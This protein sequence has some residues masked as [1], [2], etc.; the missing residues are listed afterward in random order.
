GECSADDSFTITIGTLFAVAPTPMQACDNDGDGI[1]IVDLTTKIPEITLGNSGV[2]VTFHQTNS[3]AQAGANPIAN[4]SNY[5]LEIAAPP[6]LFVRVTNVSGLCQ[7]VYPLVFDD[8]GCTGNFVS[9]TV[10]Y[11]LD[12]NGC[13][14]NDVPA[15][16]VAVS[17]TQGNTYVTTFTDANGN[18][19]LQNMEDGDV[20]VFV[21]TSGTVFTAPSPQTIT[22]PGNG[23][24]TNFCITAPNPVTDISVSVTPITQARPGFAVSYSLVF[25]NLGTTQ[26]SGNISLTFPTQ[27]MTFT[28][29]APAMVQSGNALT[30]NY[31]NLMPFETR[32]IVIDF[33]VMQPPTVNSGTVLPLVASIN[34]VSGDAN[35]SNNTN[36]L[37][38]IVVNSYDPNDIDVREG[39][40]ITMAQAGDYLHYTVRFQNTGDASATFVRVETTLDADLDWNTLQPISSSHDFT[41]IRQGSALTFKFDDI[42]LAG[43]QVNEPESHGYVIY[44][45][46]PKATAALGDVFSASVNIF[47][48]FNAQVATNVVTTTIVPPMGNKDFKADM[49]TVYPNPASANVNLQL[50]NTATADV[51]VTD[52]LGNTVLHSKL[53]SAD[54]N[55]DI[56]NLNS[57][58]YFITVYAEGKSITKKLM[59]K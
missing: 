13:T 25:Q 11:D 56:S 24:N 39:E 55:L 37:N 35:P 43:E 22:F 41:T 16:F 30:Y 7:E 53:Q 20:E 18:Y 40:F 49:F 32:T 27:F 57:G 44:R 8:S 38:H 52:V 46:K 3:S 19:M 51:V 1:I 36:T 14:E 29:S 45:I 9:G 47:F 33:M 28:Q 15:S 12:N 31:T 21:Q 26:A 42:N 58:M 17:Y 48:D 2:I 10:T 59:V 6:V 23:E 5:V 50:A 54:T 34:P 4:P